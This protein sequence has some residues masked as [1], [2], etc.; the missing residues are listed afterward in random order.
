MSC[1]SSPFQLLSEIEFDKLSKG[2]RRKKRGVSRQQLVL[3]ERMSMGGEEWGG[4]GLG[5]SL[6]FW[7]EN[8]VR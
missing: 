4:G 8:S 6:G 7:V 2:K 1:L 3:F 5:L